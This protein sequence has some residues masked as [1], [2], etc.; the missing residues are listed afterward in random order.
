MES[1]ASRRT[2][3]EPTWRPPGPIRR[4]PPGP[5]P[6]PRPSAGDAHVLAAAGRR[7]AHGGTIGVA[8]LG[9][10][11]LAP[12]WTGVGRLTAD[13]G[14]ATAGPGRGE[15]GLA[16]VGVETLAIEIVA[17]EGPPLGFL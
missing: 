17:L 7:R 4:C 11:D 16:M 3:A 1:T 12:R 10:V 5:G 6:P 13:P 2:G 9:L 8:P 14:V 15:P